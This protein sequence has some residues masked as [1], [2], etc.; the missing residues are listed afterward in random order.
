MSW[1]MIVL[2]ESD[3]S[4]PLAR[5]FLSLPYSRQPRQGSYFDTAIETITRTWPETPTFRHLSIVQDVPPRFSVPHLVKRMARVKLAKEKQEQKRLLQEAQG[6]TA[7]GEVDGDGEEKKRD[8]LPSSDEANSDSGSEPSDDDEAWDALADA[9]PVEPK[10]GYTGQGPFPYLSG[11]LADAKPSTF[12]QPVVFHDITCLARL[13]R[14]PGSWHVRDLRL[15][16]PGRDVVKTLSE[17]GDTPH[18][19][20]GRRWFPRLRYLDVSTSNVRLDGW[21]PV[22]LRRY[23]KLEHIV[24]DRTNLFGFRGKDSGQILCA[25]LARMCAGMVGIQRAKERERELT[26]LEEV[27]RRREAVL[28]RE[29]QRRISAERPIREENEGEEDGED[30]EEDEEE[31]EFDENGDPIERP[32]R[33]RRPVP[34]PEPEPEPV[35]YRA[36]ERARPRRNRR[37]IAVATFSVRENSRRNRT[38]DRVGVEDDA[39]LVIPPPQSICMVLPSLSRL[40]SV[41]L[42]GESL[43]LDQTKLD[44]WEKG[45]RAGWKDGID[46]AYEWATRVGERYDRALKAAEAWKSA[47]QLEFGPGSKTAKGKRGPSPLLLPNGKPR[48]RPPLDVRLYRYPWPQETI[49][50][51]DEVADPDDPYAGLIRVET[52]ENWKDVYLRYLGEAGERCAADATIVNQDGRVDPAPKPEIS[53]STLSGPVLCC[54]PDCEGPMRRGDGGERVDGRAGMKLVNGRVVIRGG[55]KH[56]PGC[57]HA[58]AANVWSNQV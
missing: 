56:K 36:M 10:T 19:A 22:L 5:R 50:E 29:R 30:E 32:P 15:R 31:L 58:Y 45:F 47:E 13:A 46:K 53:S 39:D 8:G 55:F 12:A 9:H 1:Q 11:R 2:I 26:R 41:N 38:N 43:P 54:I 20:Q 6:G 25:D 34:E 48:T 17:G 27:Q 28:E 24:L 18:D 7:S 42:G 14:S 52:D 4:R 37:T 16:C 35:Q 21:L 57:G 33:R 23:S 49:R 44:A 3:A 40:K 51:E